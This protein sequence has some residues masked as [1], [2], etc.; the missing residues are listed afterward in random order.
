MRNVYLKANQMRIMPN[1]A[2]KLLQTQRLKMRMMQAMRR[3]GQAV[4]RQSQT[5]MLRDL[6]LGQLPL[7]QH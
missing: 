7:R 4:G 5:V 6:M 3:I 2:R 1:Q